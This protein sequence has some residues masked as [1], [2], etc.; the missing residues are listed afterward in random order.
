VTRCSR[1]ARIDSLR[2]TASASWSSSAPG[3]SRPSRRATSCSVLQAPCSSMIRQIPT[4]PLDLTDGRLIVDY[5]VGDSTPL[6]QVR[7]SDHRRVQHRWP[8]SLGEPG[9]TSSTAAANPIGA[10]DTPRLLKSCRRAQRPGLASRTSTLALSSSAPRCWAIQTWTVRRTSSTSRDSR[11]VYNTTVKDSTD[12]WWTHGDFNYDGVVD[13]LGPGGAGPQNYNTALPS[14]PIPGASAGFEADLARAFAS[15]PEPGALGIMSAV[16]LATLDSAS[17]SSRSLIQ[18][19][20]MTVCARPALRPRAVSGS[21]GQAC[22]RIPRLQVLAHLKVSIGPEAPQVRR[23][24]HRAII[25]PEQTPLHCDATAGNARCLQPNRTT[26]ATAPP[27]SLRPRRISQ[28]DDA[29]AGHLQRL[30]RFLFEEAIQRIGQRRFSGSMRVAGRGRRRGCVVP[31]TH[32]RESRLTP[33]RPRP[34][35]GFFGHLVAQ[36]VDA[37]QHRA[38]FVVSAKDLC[39]SPPQ[40]VAQAPQP[41]APHPPAG[42]CPSRRSRS[43]YHTRATPVTRSRASS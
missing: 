41:P 28:A 5:A 11:R 6:A 26:P 9:I 12:S 32:R 15:V 36:Q 4:R 39:R 23:H 24:L 18:D 27:A 40:H 10:S 3:Q 29:A 14:A 1:R 22:L 34:A 7:G 25:R 38:C 19:V 2:R 17:A 20:R 16:A 21:S 35:R 31:R 13:F 43:R 33:R 8:V 42:H 30:G 37:Q